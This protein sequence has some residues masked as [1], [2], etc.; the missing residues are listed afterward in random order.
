MKS[1]K[2]FLEEFEAAVKPAHDFLR[3]NFHPHAVIIINYDGAHVLEGMIGIP[4]L[5]REKA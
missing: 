4:D 5:D 1:K 3:K 2:V